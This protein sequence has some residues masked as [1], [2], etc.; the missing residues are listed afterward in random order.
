MHHPV[1]MSRVGSALSGISLVAALIDFDQT[2]ANGPQGRLSAR[3]KAK[4]AQDVRDMRP[5]RSL[6]DAELRGDLFVGFAGPDNAKNVE[7]ASCHRRRG[8]AI[9]SRISARQQS[10]CDGRVELELA[11]MSRP[12]RRGNLIGLCIFQQISGRAR[13]QRGVNASLFSE[14]SQ[15]HHF[16]IAVAGTDLARRSDAVWRRHLKIHQDDMGQTRMRVELRKQL[17]CLRPSIGVPDEDEIRLTREKDDK[18]TP[19]DCV[20][21]DDEHANSLTLERHPAVLGLEG[22]RSE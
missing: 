17:Q 16:D 19:H 2:L 10:S 1:G 20:V 15:Y 22:P 8:I 11:T 4:L 18:T 9:R 14:G 21:V 3:V 12:N 7:L 13:F 6:A 5:R